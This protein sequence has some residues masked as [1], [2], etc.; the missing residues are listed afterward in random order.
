[1]IT[2]LEKIKYLESKKTKCPFC[3]SKNIHIINNDNPKIISMD[4]SELELMCN[5]CNKHWIEVF[6]NFDIYEIGDD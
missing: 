4:K 3:E 6:P 5:D 1:M 2:S